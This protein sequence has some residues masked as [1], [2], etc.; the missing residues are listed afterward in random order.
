GFGKHRSLASMTG[1]SAAAQQRELD[2]EAR[3]CANRRPAVAPQSVVRRAAGKDAGT[4]A[5]GVRVRTQASL[6]AAQDARDRENGIRR[7]ERRRAAPMPEADKT[8]RLTGRQKPTRVH[9]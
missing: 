3:S 7:A 9:R 8:S 2:H 1:W 6:R 5:S 4:H